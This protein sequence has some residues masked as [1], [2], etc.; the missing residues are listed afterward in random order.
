MK[1]QRALYKHHLFGEATMI[2]DCHCHAGK[3]DGLT[4]PW[5]T[6]APLERYMRWAAQA[7]INKTAL[8]AAFHFDYDETVF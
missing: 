8:F 3:G 5:D 4:S 7:G 6:A 1:G 2:I